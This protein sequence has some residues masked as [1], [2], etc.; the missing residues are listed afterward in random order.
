MSIF[1]IKNLVADYQT[2]IRLSPSVIKA[3]STTI[4]TTSM[5]DWKSQYQAMFVLFKDGDN[6]LLDGRHRA[7][8]THSVC[9]FFLNNFEYNTE[10]ED[11]VAARGVISD[12]VKEI[13]SNTKPFA[14][15]QF[16]KVYAIVSKH[17]KKEGFKIKSFESL[18]N[19]LESYIVL[20]LNFQGDTARHFFNSLNSGSPIKPI[21]AFFDQYYGNTKRRK[22]CS[23][24]LG[25]SSLTHT[26]EANS[27]Q[28]F[29]T[30]VVGLNVDIYKDLDLIRKTISK[31]GF[32]AL[33]FNPG[34]LPEDEKLLK[35]YMDR[36]E[37]EVILDADSFKELS[38]MYRGL[39]S[40]ARDSYR[41]TKEESKRKDRKF[42]NKTD[43]VI[44]C[45]TALITGMLYR[46]TI[47]ELSALNALD[48]LVSEQRNLGQSELR[49][50]AF[51]SIISEL[52]ITKGDK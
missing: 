28:I 14:S 35:S 26:Q 17:L 21:V 7:L 11:E 46:R 23:A 2:E 33:G 27:L 30:L 9:R 40:Y 24:L 29:F 1:I 22:Y 52:K 39:H 15:H 20:P 43:K 36:I 49:V 25:N 12:W 18:H 10:D 45:Y 37:E 5:S 19:R 34:I 6:M 8:V 41:S 16:D 42:Q 44:G 51:N 38:N 47:T 4:V 3:I 13:Q 31:H 48:K 50:Q 32:S